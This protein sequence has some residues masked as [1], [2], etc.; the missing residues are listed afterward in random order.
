METFTNGGREAEFIWACPR[1]QQTPVTGGQSSCAMRPL[2]LPCSQDRRGIQVTKQRLPFRRTCVLHTPCEHR[3][4]L[5]R[6]EKTMLGVGAHLAGVRLAARRA[7]C[8]RGAPGRALRSP[9]SAPDACRSGSTTH[10]LLL[11]CALRNRGQSDQALMHATGADVSA[12][13][14]SS[15]LGR[16]AAAGAGYHNSDSIYAPTRQTEEC[17]IKWSGSRARM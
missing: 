16:R 17:P 14:A 12:E 6:K 10:G 9:A 3:R 13:G 2:A 5:G 11:G 15:W 8:C 1:T 4:R 7:P